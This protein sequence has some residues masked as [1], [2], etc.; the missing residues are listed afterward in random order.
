[1]ASPDCRRRL[2]RE[3]RAIQRD[4]PPHILA[5]PNAANI[6]E[7]HY[8]ITGPADSPYAKGEYHGK[9]KFPSNYPHRP[10]SIFML[11]PSGRFQVNQRLCL[12]MSD[13][14]PETWNPMWSV[15]SVLIGLMSFMLEDTETAGSIITS[16]A[17]KQKFAALSHSYNISNPAFRLHFPE[18]LP[19]SPS[20]TPPSP[21]QGPPPVSPI[22]APRRVAP[23]PAQDTRTAPK[24]AGFGD[25]ILLIVLALFGA[26]VLNQML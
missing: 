7:W 24:N 3:I 5:R 14:H 1:M 15:S 12:S 16:T 4:P 9:I 2:Q 18:L 23:A 10:P 17:T 21:S 6:L 13:Y 19:S 25:N 26:L 22:P 8:I 11:T 20:S